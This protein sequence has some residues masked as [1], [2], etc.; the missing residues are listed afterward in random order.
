[1]LEGRGEVTEIALGREV[2]GSRL[3]DVVGELTVWGP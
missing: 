2:E 3:G 1:M